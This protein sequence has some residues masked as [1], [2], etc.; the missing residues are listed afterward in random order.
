LSRTRPLRN[1]AFRRL[2][3]A[4]AISR[5]GDILA[6]VAMA[7]VVWDRTHSTFATTGLFVA[8]EFLP[9]LA[10][11]PLVA[12][13]DRLP[14][15][16]VLTTLYLLEAAVFA[17]LALLTE[18]FSLAPFLLLVAIDGALGVV[19]RSL[20]RG[21][22][23]A[24]LEPTGDLRAGNA[25]LNLAVAPSMAIG[26]VV[27]GLLV[28]TAGAG[29]AL[30]VNAA[31]FAAGALLVRT[32]RGLPAYAADVDERDEHWRR[33][34]G[35]TLRYV[36]GRRLVLALLAGQAVALVFFSMTEPIE[37]AYTRDALDAGPGGYGALIA[38][39]GGGG[40][41]GSAI[42]AWVGS[43][44]LLAVAIGSTLLQG[45]AFLG[46]AVAPTIEVACAVAVVGGAANGAQLVA[47]ATAIQEA[48]EI[49]QQARVMSLYESIATATPGIGYLLGGAVA[50]AAGGRAAFAVAGGGVLLALAGV[51]AMRPWRARDRRVASYAEA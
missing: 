22:V 47:L 38:T 37:V 8:L 17:V 25:L 13:L 5:I 36:R 12:R 27:G 11:P 2:G 31:T 6:L 28:A 42:Y 32:A 24:V 46:I 39:W 20:C 33:R 23:A 43:S 49:D 15:G 14:I 9:A 3:S 18:Q 30:V 1:P 45:L 48:V 7:L 19:A 40:V 4:Y 26:G 21:A 34:L 10:G 50:A 44:R 41:V 16:R 35:A 51:A 29:T